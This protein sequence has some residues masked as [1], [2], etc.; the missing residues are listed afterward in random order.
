MKISDE[1][2]IKNNAFVE[3]IAKEI[4]S[5]NNRLAKCIASYVRNGIEDF[6]VD[7]LSDEQMRELNPLIRN[8]VYTFLVDFKGEM[9]KIASDENIK[10]CINAVIKNTHPFLLQ[11]G[12][13]PE[14]TNIFYESVSDKLDLILYEIS[15]G[16]KMLV[17]QEIAFVPKYWED[18][19][20]IKQL[21]SE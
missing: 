20:Y 2:N 11:V 3:K 21:K 15:K 18:C 12:L 9:N 6:H 4:Y 7:Y 8:A 17:G 16:G 14:L 13:T 19:V 5:D 10:C 1:E